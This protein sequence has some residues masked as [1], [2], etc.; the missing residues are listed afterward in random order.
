M[1]S[2]DNY[3]NVLSF[4]TAQVG[5]THIAQS[6]MIMD[7]T[8]MLDPQTKKCYIYDYFHEDPSE[9]DKRMGI[10]YKRDTNK[11]ECYCKYIVTQY[12]TISSDQVEYH[13]QFAPS[14]N[15]A[16]MAWYSKDD[17][18]KKTYK[19]VYDIDFPIGLY[20]DIP[21]EKGI[22]R[23]WMFCGRNDNLQ[24][25]SYSIVQCN[26]Y[27]H[28]IKNHKIQKMW[29][30]AR[31]RSS[32]NVGTWVNDVTSTPENQDQIWIPLNEVS[33]ELFYDDRLLLSA[34]RDTP[35]AWKIAKVETLHPIG[36]NK[37]TLSQD[38]YNA[39]TDY[40]P[41]NKA[42]PYEMYANYYS[43]SIT[44][45]DTTTDTSSAYSIITGRSN[46]K[47][48]GSG[49]IL[50]VLFTDSDATATHTINTNTW[51]F[52]DKS[53]GKDCSDWISVTSIENY[54]KIKIVLLKDESYIGKIIVCKV[55]D[56]NGKCASSKEL[57]I[58]S[59]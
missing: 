21:D 24:F 14:F 3:A 37:Y 9:K 48:N 22:Y 52:T 53:T 26:Y 29:G 45:N 44:P 5:A 33:N 20:I 30:I 27:F 40:V 38:Q 1:L 25:P 54:S 28:W 7:K 50:S 32:Y 57:E 23:R 56:D 43:S 36:I 58:I 2:L 4:Q 55:S 47:V 19:D 31:L 46:I 34:S 18:Y 35:L 42:T 10:E 51:T 16:V 12:P 11:A 17:Y 49:T 8:W 6:N 15:P 59:L 41:A 13:I 39:N